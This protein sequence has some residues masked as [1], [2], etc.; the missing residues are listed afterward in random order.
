MLIIFLP[1][2]YIGFVC[3]RWLFQ[4]VETKNRRHNTKKAFWLLL[5]SIIFIILANQIGFSAISSEA[6]QSYWLYAAIYYLSLDLIV[7]YNFMIIR[8]TNS[9]KNITKLLIVMLSAGTM[10][11]AIWWTYD[12]LSLGVYDGKFG[13][14]KS[15][16]LEATSKF[17]GTR[18]NHVPG[19]IEKDDGYWLVN[20][21]LKTKDSS[22]KV[23]KI[24]RVSRANGEISSYEDNKSISLNLTKSGVHAEEI[25]ALIFVDTSSGANTNPKWQAIDYGVSDSSGNMVISVPKELSKKLLIT[26]N[27]CTLVCQSNYYRLS[28]PLKDDYVLVIDPRNVGLIEL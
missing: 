12:A 2:F 11:S 16:A 1:A 20:Q 7:F 14:G 27:D 21:T 18:I 17:I 23:E 6:R 28:L 4:K 8:A 26:T 22:G 5:L 24:Y 3:F 10:I 25:E 9:H 13:L 19:K 15:Q